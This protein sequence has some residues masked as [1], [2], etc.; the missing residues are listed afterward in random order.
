MSQLT[1]VNCTNKVV[2]HYIHVQFK[3]FSISTSTS[4]ATCVK[5]VANMLCIV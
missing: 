3:L 2:K 1:T 4:Y 5:D